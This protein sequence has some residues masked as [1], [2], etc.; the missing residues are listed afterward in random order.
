MAANIFVILFFIL[1]LCLTALFV[2]FYLTSIRFPG[3]KVLYNTLGRDIRA[4]LRYGRIQSLI[5]KYRLH[6]VTLVDLFRDAVKENKNKVCFISEGQEWTY[7]EIDE[8]SNRVARCFLNMGY[9]KG[10]EVALFMLNRP[11]YVCIWLGLAKI[12]V[13]TA[14]INTNQQEDSLANSINIIDTKALIYDALLTDAVINVTPYLD[15][16]DTLDYFCLGKTETNG[17]PFHSKCLEDLLQEVSPSALKEKIQINF[18]DKMLYIYTSGTTGMPKAAIIRHNRFISIGTAAKYGMN[19]SNSEIYYNPLPMYHTAGGIFLLSI[20]LIYGG[21]MVLKRKFSASNFWSDAIKHKATVS[22][23]IGEICRFLM[24]QPYRPE[25]TQHSIQKMIGNGLKSHIWK[26]FQERFKI[27]HIVEFYGAT[28]GNANLVNMFG[29]P[30][31]VGFISRVFSR[32]Y[33]VH[34]IKVNPETGE[35]LRDHNGLCIRCEPGEPGELVG[36]IVKESPLNN[37][38]GYINTS[39][40]KKKVITNCFKKGDAAFLSGDVLVMDED[41]YIY[42]M[43]RTGDTFRWKGENVSTNEVENIISKVVGLAACVVY[44]VE[45]PNVEGRAGMAAIQK[46]GEKLDVDF[47]YQNLKKML[48][49]YAIPIFIRLCHSIEATGTYKLRKVNLQKEGYNPELISDPLYVLNRKTQMYESLTQETYK[50]ICENKF[51]F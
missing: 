37:F 47:L 10:D 8:Y 17:Q 15:R 25:E 29:K 30:G 36:K 27:K 13:M 42:F 23:Y 49:F 43:D 40:T 18:N 16:K 11:E 44:G 24:N 6:N 35:P 7:Q 19:L 31:A 46:N 38:D 4:G 33:P 41:G 28:E 26:N 12:G 32:L 51:G 50:Q 2:L 21:T 39:A 1:L 34:V 20:V 5:Q 22:Q 9:Q 45:I 3:F 48:P 14:L